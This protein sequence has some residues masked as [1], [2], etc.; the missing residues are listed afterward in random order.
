[1][2][3][4]HAEAP[5]RSE[6]TDKVQEHERE[7]EEKVDEIDPIV[8]D[9]ETEAD[10]LESLQLRGTED[11]TEEVGQDIESAGEVTDEEFDEEGN[12]LEQIQEHSQEHQE[13]LDERSDADDKDR[14]AL[15]A[16]VG[17]IHSDSAGKELGAAK[18]AAEKDMEFLDEQSQR[19]QE[20]R[21]ESQRAYE[22]LGSRMN[23][24]RGR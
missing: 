6:I 5:T 1:M 9:R 21:E 19:S 22:V 20:A 13:E 23:A 16:A 4:R 2:A 12:Q 15:E 24:A 10:T 14:E 17:K 11:G 8:S 7:M 3:R 18:D